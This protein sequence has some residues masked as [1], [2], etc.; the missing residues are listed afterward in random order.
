MFPYNGY[1]AYQESQHNR[2]FNWHSTMFRAVAS[3]TVPDALEFHFPHLFPQ[4]KINFSYFSSNFTYFLPHFG[5]PGGWVATQGRPWLRHWPRLL[6]NI[7]ITHLICGKNYFDFKGDVIF[8]RRGWIPV[9][10]PTFRIVKVRPPVI[11]LFWRWKF[12]DPPINR[13][14]TPLGLVCCILY[15]SFIHIQNQVV[16]RR[17]KSCQ[18]LVSLA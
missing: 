6:H 3:L 15:M 18:N 17:E 16:L 8:F 2:P 12:H 9:V 5:P 10:G 1:A 11:F 7:I 4:I 14:R 13:P